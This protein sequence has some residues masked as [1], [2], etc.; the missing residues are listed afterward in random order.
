[1]DKR[2]HLKKENEEIKMKLMQHNNM[3]TIRRKKSQNV[4]KRH[5]TRR[6]G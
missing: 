2:K 3:K 5:R 4:A 6:L 1:M